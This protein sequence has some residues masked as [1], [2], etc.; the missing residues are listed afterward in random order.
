MLLKSGVQLLDKVHQLQE[1]LTRPPPILDQVHKQTGLM[2]SDVLLWWVH[3]LSV[4]I[5]DLEVTG[6]TEH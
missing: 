3:M 2:S 6:S 4:F 5:M 1:F